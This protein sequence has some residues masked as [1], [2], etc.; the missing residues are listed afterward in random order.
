MLIGMFVLFSY[1]FYFCRNLF[2]HSYD[3]T[4]KITLSFSMLLAEYG[5]QL[6]KYIHFYI[7]NYLQEA[8]SRIKFERKECKQST[9]SRNMQS[10]SSSRPCTSHFTGGNLLL[11]LLRCLLAKT[12]KYFILYYL[13]T[14]TFLAISYPF[15][16]QCVSVRAK[17]WAVPAPV[18]VHSS[19]LWELGTPGAASSTAQRASCFCL[20]D[21][22][23][24]SQNTKKYCLS[25]WVFF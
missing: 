6:G 13:K 24:S 2:T 4:D 10:L 21:P 12:R 3:K 19:L 5:H 11:V 20:T 7:T 18:C 25:F 14:V 22:T 1:R 8:A 15:P 23:E 17:S 9:S 16:V